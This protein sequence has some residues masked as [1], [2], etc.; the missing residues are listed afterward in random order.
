MSSTVT[1]STRR[2]SDHFEPQDIDPQEQR[3]LRG[4]LEQIDYAAFVSN[5]EILGQTLGRLDAGQF[6]KL[7]VVTAQARARWAAAALAIGR[8]GRPPEP[9]EVDRLQAL[10]TA[11]DE[12]SAAYE[13]LR[14]MIER[15][16]VP[17]G[18]PPND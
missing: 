2:F 5:R 10:R 12:L 3:R 8:T 4:Y 17:Y 9:Q 11:F 1:S 7:A 16:Y 15:G 18:P 6:Q 14:R 13:A